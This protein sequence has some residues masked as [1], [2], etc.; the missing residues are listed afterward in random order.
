MGLIVEKNLV[1]VVLNVK[2]IE[3]EWSEIVQK[4]YRDI[5]QMVLLYRMGPG[6]I[7]G[8]G[9]SGMTASHSTFSQ[10]KIRNQLRENAV[11]RL[12]DCLLR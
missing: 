8:S 10:Q 7:G 4:V 12:C 2:E 1:R 6:S 11:G 3:S 5:S 9:E